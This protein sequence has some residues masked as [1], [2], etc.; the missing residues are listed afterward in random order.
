[1]THLAKQQQKLEVAI[2]LPLFWYCLVFQCDQ[3]F[4][5]VVVSVFCVY[6]KCRI[7]LYSTYCVNNFA[8]ILPP[9]LPPFLFLKG[10]LIL[11]ELWGLV[12][13]GKVLADCLPGTFFLFAFHS[14]WTM[15]SNLLVSLR[16]FFQSFM[17]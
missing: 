15:K 8:L 10:I 9:F 11:R 1:M 3:V 13:W 7:P 16:S 12:M 14:A 2:L 5:A 4:K 17:F 6:C